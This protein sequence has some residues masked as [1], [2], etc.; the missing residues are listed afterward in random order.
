MFKNAKFAQREQIRTVPLPVS[1]DWLQNPF[2]EDLPASVAI[3][4]SS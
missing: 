4:T 3:A 2:M 1:R